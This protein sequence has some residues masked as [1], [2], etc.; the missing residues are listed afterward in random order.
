VTERDA[1]VASGLLSTSQNLGGAIGVA[2]ASSIAA[3][4]F[5]A[6]ARHGYP[7]AA[8]LTGGFH[9]AL[10]V[11]GPAGLTAIPVALILIRRTR[12]ADVIATA[13]PQD[14]VMAATR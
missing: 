13:Q 2:V 12:K 7:T 9:W 4:H 8:A 10:W 11:C 3:S 5:H 14:L 1:G 6:L